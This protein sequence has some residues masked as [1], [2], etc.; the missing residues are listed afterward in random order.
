MKDWCA[1][2]CCGVLLGVVIVCGGQSLRQ[3]WERAADY[4]SAAAPE[5]APISDP[6]PGEPPEPAPPGEL[7]EGVFRWVPGRWEEI[8]PLRPV[9]QKQLPQDVYDQPSPATPS[10]D[11]SFTWIPGHWRPLADGEVI[12]ET[13]PMPLKPTDRRPGESFDEWEKR[14]DSKP[15]KAD[16]RKPDP[17]AD[18]ISPTDPMAWED[19]VDRQKAK[20]H[21]ETLQPEP[22]AL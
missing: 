22:S 11:Y 16:E 4:D 6:W 5:A 17:V 10:G 18:W 9:D 1:G 20:E 7:G 3:S 12:T 13:P 8:E 19:W 21:G 2:L 14:L 15:P